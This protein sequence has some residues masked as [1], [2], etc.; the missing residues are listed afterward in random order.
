MVDVIV[1]LSESYKPRV[2]IVIIIIS[3]QTKWHG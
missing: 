2:I 1:V 3:T